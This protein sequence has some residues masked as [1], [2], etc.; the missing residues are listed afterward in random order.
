MLFRSAN[1]ELVAHADNGWILPDGTVP[2]VTDLGAL[3]NRADG[4][5][6]HNRQWVSEHALFPQAVDLFVQR[7]KALS[8]SR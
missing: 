5:G 6:D 2:D 7:L 3:R 8:T 4:I 1:R